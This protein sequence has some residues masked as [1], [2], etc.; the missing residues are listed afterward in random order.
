MPLES[1]LISVDR[2][3]EHVDIILYHSSAPF[4]LQLRQGRIRNA[5]ILYF[6][7][8]PHIV[9]DALII[10]RYRLTHFYF[11]LMIITTALS[12]ILPAVVA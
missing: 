5:V 7:P 12:G 8:L 1:T 2:D 6:L 11:G 10:F 4:C 3:D 9:D